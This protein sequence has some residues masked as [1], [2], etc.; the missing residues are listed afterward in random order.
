MRKLIAIGVLV[1]VA[2]AVV[3][4]TALA[5]TKVVR[6]GDNYF[7]RSSGVP[8]VT[9]ER[10]TVVAWRWVGDSP[11]NVVVTSGPVKFRSSTMR[12]GTFRKRMTRAGRYTII[13][14]IHGG[15]DQKMILRVK[16]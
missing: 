7:V 14:R 13:C 2:G 12:S 8:G 15:G 16:R 1:A 9:V 3:V 10:G 5:A 6:V 4:G 11:H